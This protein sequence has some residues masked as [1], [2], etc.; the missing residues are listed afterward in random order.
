MK[1][2][3]DYINE[4]KTSRERQRRKNL[5]HAL[6]YGSKRK[7]LLKQMPVTEVKK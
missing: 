6:M 1:S 2:A 4:A 5:C 3:V 7:L